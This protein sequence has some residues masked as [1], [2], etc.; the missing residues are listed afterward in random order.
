MNK[1]GKNVSTFL[2]FARFVH[3]YIPVLAILCFLDNPVWAIYLFLYNELAYLC[4]I[5]HYMPFKNFSWHFFYEK[6]VFIVAIYHLFLFSDLT[7]F[8]QKIGAGVSIIAFIIVQSAISLALDIF[9]GTFSSLADCKRSLN[10]KKLK[11]KL[12]AKR[13]EVKA[14]Q[15]KAPQCRQLIFTAAEPKGDFHTP[16]AIVQL[17]KDQPVNV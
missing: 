3:Q 4:L 16:S 2:V 11:R 5:L 6:A 14:S 13:L 1:V 12:N 9:F 8:D 15:S 17:Y 7:N 10:K